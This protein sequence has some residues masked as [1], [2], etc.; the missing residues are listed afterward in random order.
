[1]IDALKNRSVKGLLWAASESAGVATISFVGFVV[2]A[3][4]LS[5]EDFGV[6]ALATVFVYF[7]NLITGHNFAD[8][9][10]QRRELDAEHLD[11]AFWSTLG[12]ALFLMA[13]CLLGAGPVSDWM[14]EPDL[15]EAL[16]W[17][18]VLL[19]LAA[20]SSVQM[21]MFRREMR[22]DAVARRVLLGRS[23]GAVAGITAALNGYGFWSLVIQQIVGQGATTAAFYAGAWLPRLRFCPRRFRE[24]FGFGMHVS[25]NQVISGAGEQVLNLSV[26]ALFGTVALGYFTL[27][28]RAVNLIRS[29]VSSAVYQVGLSA[30]SK[31]QQDRDAVARSFLSATRISCLIGF[32]IGA[33]IA[34]VNEPLVLAMFSDHWRESIPL[35]A[36]LALELIPGFYTMFI[37]AL[38]RSMDRPSWGL[39]MAVIYTA[40]GLGCAYATAPFGVEAVAVVWVARAFVLLPIHVVL[41]H[42]LLGLSPARLLSPV[43]SPMI[44]VAAM[45]LG[46]LAL[47]AGVGET[48][49]PLASLALLIPAG[50]VIYGG[51]IVMLSPDLVG[52]T[53]R[54]LGR[55]RAPA[56]G[57][58]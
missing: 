54:T 20:L 31:L 16:R 1:M 10:V 55:A 47:R 21:A 58:T 34:L 38:Y 14:G 28:W 51:A 37:S 50:G 41:L 24:L 44:A 8:A 26:G 45:T 48:L 2:L 40:T 53:I 13:A 7:C 27:A 43:V 57:S 19:P 49:G 3:R 39:A 22:F 4:L 9:L 46:L 33:G 15:A 12:L 18:S 11:T 23:L 32:P 52:L 6:V 29:L 30:F 35:M 56:E 5:P 25:A 17:L 42:R 36:I